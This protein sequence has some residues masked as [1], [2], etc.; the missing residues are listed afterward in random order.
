M[1]GTHAI[2]RFAVYTVHLRPLL[3]GHATQHDAG[4]HVAFVAVVAA[5][6]LFPLFC[7]SSIQSSAH[8]LKEVGSTNA[9]FEVTAVLR[10][11][12]WRTQL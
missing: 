9:G 8:R 7:A 11:D 5:L 12:F 10:G 4:D 2:A 3:S 1:A 6:R